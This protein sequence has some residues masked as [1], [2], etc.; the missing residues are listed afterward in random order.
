MGVK[1]AGVAKLVD[2][3]ALGAN[4]FGCGG[5]SPLPG[6]RRKLTGGFQRESVISYFGTR[7]TYAEQL[8]QR[9]TAHAAY[10]GMKEL[11]A[12][13]KHVLVVQGD[14][15][16][17]YTADTLKSFIEGHVQSN[18]V[19]SLLTATVENPEQLGRI[20][21]HSNGDIEIIEKEYLTDEQKL[22]HEISTGTFCFNRDWY[23]K[24]FPSMPQLRKLGEFGLPTALAMARNQKEKYKLI[25]LEDNNEWFGINTPEQLTQ[26]VDKKREKVSLVRKKTKTSTLRVAGLKLLISFVCLNLVTFLKSIV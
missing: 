19:L 2:A 1:N 21:R 23:E 15:S 24:M 17:F 3:F 7:C 11:P 25:P 10:V 13:A 26:A 22:I 20:V 5:S 16:A 8:E 9:G 4:A 6:T 14:D 18:A 12:H